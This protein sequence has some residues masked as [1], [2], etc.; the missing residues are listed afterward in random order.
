MGQDLIGAVVREVT[1]CLGDKAA[2]VTAKWLDDESRIA[3][4]GL[5]PCGDT[6]EVT[7]GR[8][9]VEAEPQEWSWWAA[10]CIRGR[11]MEE[12]W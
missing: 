1:K 5:A 10:R 7:G 4:V 3:V 8:G 6:H 9:M 12:G 11:F 2:G